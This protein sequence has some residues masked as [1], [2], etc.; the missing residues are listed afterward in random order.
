MKRAL[1][2]LLLL[3]GCGAQG[4]KL[5]DGYRD[6]SALIGS[7]SRYDAARFKGAWVVRGSFDADAPAT[8]AFVD[9][10]GGPAFQFCDSDGACDD[11]WP[12][13]STGQGRYALTGPDGETKTFWVLWVDEGFRTAAVGNPAGDFGWILDRKPTGGADRIR[14]AQEILD[15]NG[16]DISQLRMRK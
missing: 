12:A 14:A 6:P 10:R 1:L 5:T 15:F 16:Y 8:V 7:T 4:P 3:A 9:S 2:A 13:T 11:V